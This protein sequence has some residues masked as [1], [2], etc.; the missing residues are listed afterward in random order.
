MAPRLS[1][2]RR[3]SSEFTPGKGEHNVQTSAQGEL[4]E[5]GDTL[6]YPLD[7]AVTHENHES[8][9]APV[10]ILG[11]TAALETEEDD[12]DEFNYGL[13]ARAFGK[14][15]NRSVITAWPKHQKAPIGFRSSFPP[16]Q[17]GDRPLGI[18]DVS[19]ELSATL[20]EMNIEIDEYGSLDHL[21]STPTTITS[22]GPRRTQSRP[23]A[24]PLAPATVQDKPLGPVPA[25]KEA[26]K[27]ARGS[28]AQQKDKVRRNS[29]GQGPASKQPNPAEERRQREDK[30]KK[31][32]PKVSQTA[33]KKIAAERAE[34]NLQSDPERRAKLVEL[35]RQYYQLSDVTVYQRA[36]MYKRAVP[37]P[38]KRKTS[39][40]RKRTAQNVLPL[41]TTF[42]IENKTQE[43]EELDE[44][45][46]D[47]A[48]VQKQTEAA[49]K[50]MQ[51]KAAPSPSVAPDVDEEP[52]PW[53]R[54]SKQEMLAHYRGLKRITYERRFYEFLKPCSSKDRDKEWKKLRQL[55]VDP[56]LYHFLVATVQHMFERHGAK[57]PEYCEFWWSPIVYDP[58]PQKPKPGTEA[59]TEEY[60][61]FKR[62]HPKIVEDWE[63]AVAE[64]DTRGKKEDEADLKRIEERRKE[65]KAQ[66]E[67]IEE[68]EKKR[69]E[70]QAD[71]IETIKRRYQN[72]S[73]KRDVGLEPRCRHEVQ[74]NHCPQCRVYGRPPFMEWSDDDLCERFALIER[75]EQEKKEK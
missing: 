56:K 36:C 66:A 72:G 47:F 6:A 11:T 7:P 8:T 60:K 53:I 2:V 14:S 37:A 74:W 44:V 24:A 35:V 34:T 63:K 9:A 4:R 54:M 17:F 42:E 16:V 68:R 64:R 3:L 48:F 43:E 55:K 26:T 70:A 12:D 58:E 57:Q 5:F 33:A 38:K 27:G 73:L 39:N 65:R 31:I 21:V 52:I 59:E 32:S 62:K 13:K 10:T 67:K 20:T 22:V 30:G 45:W 40:K 49:V 51:T 29:S 23:L 41:I 18:G 1:V 28:T 75:R 61:R 19:S 50:A 15:C 69:K 25:R 71:T 46:A